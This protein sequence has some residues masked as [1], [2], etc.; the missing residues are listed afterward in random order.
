MEERA[1]PLLQRLVEDHCGKTLEVLYYV[2]P[3]CSSGG[4]GGEEKEACVCRVKDNGS[5]RAAA[6]T[7][8]SVILRLHAPVCA[9]GKGGGNATGA[10]EV[11]PKADGGESGEGA[12]LWDFLEELRVGSGD[13][14]RWSVARPGAPSSTATER[15]IALLPLTD[16]SLCEVLSS[17]E[18]QTMDSFAGGDTSTAAPPSRGSYYLH[19]NI[20]TPLAFFEARGGHVLS[21]Y[22]HAGTSLSSA[23]KY[24]TPG[25][26]SWATVGLMIYQIAQLVKF[27]HE[28]G[29]YFGDL[30]TSKV[31][32]ND[33]ALVFALVD[34][35]KVCGA[36]SAP[37]DGERGA[38]GRSSEAVRELSDGFKAWRLGAM[39]NF[40]YLMM[41][42]SAC[43]RERGNLDFYPVLPWV[44]DMMADPSADEDVDG[45]DGDGGTWR[46][47]TK[48]KWRLAKG[49]LQL[50][51]TYI[52]SL[53]PHHV[54]D[55]ALSE[56]TVCVYLARRLQKTVLTNVVRA[57]EW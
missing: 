53:P 29:L 1:K 13:A 46:D 12:K 43:G 21:V 31:F 55:E 32:V 6:P 44:I 39:S 11:G 41:L 4:G 24:S 7:T 9:T 48:T 50:D 54:S 10:G 30:S 36:T 40:D 57:G 18:E 28:R 26:L 49:D 8:S 17:H 3:A 19:P 27:C 34:Y 25:F 51:M 45:G 22:S 23:L 16:A 2:T 20:L 37:Q 15:E 5:D 56:L 33:Q 14:E 38:P 35:R 42:N 47:L 52:S